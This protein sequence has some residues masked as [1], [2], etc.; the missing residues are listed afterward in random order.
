MLTKTI[1]E[2]VRLS[3]LN[4]VISINSKTTAKFSK[5]NKKKTP[6]T[7]ANTPMGLTL[8]YAFWPTESNNVYSIFTVRNLAKD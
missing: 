7:L 4:S 1:Q 8:R 3:F 2:I 6:E 5:K